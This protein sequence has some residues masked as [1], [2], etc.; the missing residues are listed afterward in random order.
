MVDITPQGSTG[1]PKESM[2]NQGVENWWMN[3]LVVK[4]WSVNVYW[5]VTNLQPNVSVLADVHQ[6]HPHINDVNSVIRNEKGML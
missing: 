1:S 4:R 6:R 3:S 5:G 2:N